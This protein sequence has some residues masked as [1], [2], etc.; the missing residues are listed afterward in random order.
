MSVSLKSLSTN[1]LNIKNIYKNDNLT[2]FVI[3]LTVI[4]NSILYQ[5]GNDCLRYSVFTLG[6][7]PLI[8][9]LGPLILGSSGVEAALLIVELKFV[10]LPT[11]PSLE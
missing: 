3:F 5:A 8:R 9:V 7:V 6:W 11:T 2:N 4:L 10:N 1:S